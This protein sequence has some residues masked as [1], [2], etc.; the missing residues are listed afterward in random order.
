MILPT[1]HCYQCYQAQIAVHEGTPPES[2]RLVVAGATMQE[3]SGMLNF[4]QFCGLTKHGTRR[5]I[6]D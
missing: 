1:Q 4:L 3:I 5:T 6:T 2:Q